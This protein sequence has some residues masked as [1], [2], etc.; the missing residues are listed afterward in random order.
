MNMDKQE[1]YIQCKICKEYFDEYD[2]D[3]DICRTCE[4]LK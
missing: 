1:D 3:G 2:I 4:N